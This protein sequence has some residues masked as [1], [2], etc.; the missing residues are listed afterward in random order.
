MGPSYSDR[1]G[2]EVAG[3]GAWRLLIM[4]AFGRCVVQLVPVV[5]Q[6]KDEGLVHSVVGF[7]SFS[8]RQRD[9]SGRGWGGSASAMRVSAPGASG[10]GAVFLPR[11]SL[12][13][14]FATSFFTATLVMLR[15][16]PAAFDMGTSS[17]EIWWPSAKEGRA[18]CLGIWEDGSVRVR[19]FNF[20]VFFH[21]FWVLDGRRSSR[22]PAPRP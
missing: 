20:F 12:R 4:H 13:W 21:R 8:L 10:G 2:V 14:R 16:C 6:G 7:A 17:G 22:C 3:R 11:F 9:F 1:T 19:G 18:G 5:K 15:F